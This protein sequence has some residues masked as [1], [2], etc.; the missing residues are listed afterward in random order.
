MDETLAIG[1]GT[2]LRVVSHDQ[3][4]LEV[5]ATYQGG[6]SPPPAHLHPAQD[7]RFEVRAGAMRTRIDGQDGVVGAGETIEVPRNTVHQ[8]WND[9]DEPAVVTWR[10]S[11]AGRTLE[12]FRE[13]AALQRGEASAEPAV[14]LEQYSDVFR[15]G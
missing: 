1:P 14:L 2:S 12:W 4:L 6:G 5:E 10:T 15:L 11:P 3:A 8:M 7:E 13:L 9:S